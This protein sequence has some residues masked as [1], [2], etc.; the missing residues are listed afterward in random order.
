MDLGTGVRVVS[1]G[2]KLL[3]RLA[4]VAALASIC[5]SAY[6]IAHAQTGP[7]WEVPVAVMQELRTFPLISMG[8]A[9]VAALLYFG[10]S[11]W[12]T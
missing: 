7:G 6:V 5:L 4:L 1:K 12:E 11:R 3:F 10:S 8:L 9:I 2:G